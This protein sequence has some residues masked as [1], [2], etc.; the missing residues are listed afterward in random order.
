MAFI[1]A[2]NDLRETQSESTP[3][4]RKKI[5]FLENPRKTTPVC[6]TLQR[7]GHFVLF[8]EASK[9]LPLLSSQSACQLQVLTS[10][11]ILT[12]LGGERSRQLD[13]RI[14]FFMFQNS[15]IVYLLIE[16]LLVF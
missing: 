3:H 13:P 10:C 6:K 7:R 14:W 11:E 16:I 9:H 8:V 2:S 5:V 15:T 1:R 12:A 4:K